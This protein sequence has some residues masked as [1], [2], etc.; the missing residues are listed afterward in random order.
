MMADPTKPSEHLGNDYD[1]ELD[2]T[3]IDEEVDVPEDIGEAPFVPDY[4]DADEDTAEEDELDDDLDS[5]MAALDG[6]QGLE[7]NDGRSFN[8]GLNI[9]DAAF[10]ERRRQ[11]EKAVLYPLDE[12]LFSQVFGEFCTALDRGDK[13]VNATDRVASAMKEAV[14]SKQ[15]FNP[16]G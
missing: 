10:A 14:R 13:L 16:Q 8:E 1:A 2:I 4:E 6:A 5:Q 3:S 7:V 11:A 12:E 15:G 9:T